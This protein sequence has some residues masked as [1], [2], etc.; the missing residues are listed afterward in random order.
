MIALT[1]DR[2]HCSPVAPCFGTSSTSY[3]DGPDGHSK[4][5][6]IHGEPAVARAQ[7]RE[8][9]FEYIKV[10][11]NRRRRHSAIGRRSPKAFEAAKK[12]DTA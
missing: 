4:V 10:H 2:K 8:C 6:A 3:G 1:A 11:Y 12:G 5:E 9:V 7:L